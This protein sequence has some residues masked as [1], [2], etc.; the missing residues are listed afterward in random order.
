MQH[1]YCFEAVNRTRNDICG[2]MDG[3]YFGQIPVLLGGD[4]AQILPVIPKGNR[5]QTVDAC[6]QKSHIW[7]GI[8]VLNLNQNMRVQPGFNNLEFVSWLRNLSYNSNC[9]GQ[10]PLPAFIHTVTNICEF[11]DFVY[12]QHLL[13]IAHQQYT[14]FSNRAILTPHNETMS[15]LNSLLLAQ[16]HGELHIFNSEDT[17]DINDM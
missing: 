14:I 16:L 2:S 15:E 13:Q 6:I 4:F 1:K 10:I 7:Q 17:A 11:C 5:A 9:Y 3:I 12:P 8:L